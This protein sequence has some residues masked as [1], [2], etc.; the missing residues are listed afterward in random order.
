VVQGLSEWWLRDCWAAWHCLHRGSRIRYDVDD[1][2]MHDICVSDEQVSHQMLGSRCIQAAP[3]GTGQ[4]E[5][6]ERTYPISPYA[7][8]PSHR[9]NYGS[10]GVF[11]VRFLP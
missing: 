5:Y 10:L 4:D 7:L 1:M 6:F 3:E 2:R 11:N 8:L 9:A